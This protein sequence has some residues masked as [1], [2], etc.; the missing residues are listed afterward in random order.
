LILTNKLKAFIASNIST[1]EDLEMLL[2]LHAQPDREW[3]VTE[4]SHELSVDPIALLARIQEFVTKGLVSHKSGASKF[5][6]YQFAPSSEDIRTNVDALAAAYKS[7]RI[8]LIDYVVSPFR[9][10]LLKFA[11]AFK[12][13]KDDKD[14]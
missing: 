8:Q 14:G 10:D 2:L 13:K 12:L 6:N 9:D 1:L 7:S 3:D 4:I 5:S 11:N